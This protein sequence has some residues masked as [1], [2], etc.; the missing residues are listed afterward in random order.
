MPKEKKKDLKEKVK[1]KKANKRSGEDFGQPDAMLVRSQ[2]SVEIE[3]D[4]KGNMKWKIKVYHDDPA[5]AAAVAH[6]IDM[7]LKE[8]YGFLEEDE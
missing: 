2:S 6:Q 3:K 4:A 8:N 7:K 1:K 5:L